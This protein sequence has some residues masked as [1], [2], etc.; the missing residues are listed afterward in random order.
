MRK[1][2]TANPSMDLLPP[3]PPP[4]TPQGPAATADD[5]VGTDTHRVLSRVASLVAPGGGG[6]KDGAR[7]RATKIARLGVELESSVAAAPEEDSPAVLIT[8]KVA[9][10]GR[11]KDARVLQIAA[12]VVGAADL[13]LA[14][15][16]VLTSFHTYVDPGDVEID[17]SA[18]EVHG[19]GRD[20]LDVFASLPL[21]Y[22]MS[23]FEDWLASVAVHAKAVGESRVMPGLV[24]ASQSVAYD[25]AMV[26]NEVALEE[27][28]K[29]F[30][31][32][33]QDV[34][35]VGV[36]DAPEL[37]RAAFDA[38]RVWGFTHTKGPP[39]N[40]SLKS[41]A[42]KFD[43]GVQVKPHDAVD[44]A[45]LLRGVLEAAA[46]ADG[47]RRQFQLRAQKVM[48]PLPLCK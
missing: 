15:A 31:Q 27:P 9:T 3:A 47:G 24:L 7:V 36:V 41:L 4:T 18:V 48:K 38:P 23:R 44:D 14:E 45:A 28:G 39:K 10:S 35:F 33:L 42:A 43:A 11:G 16:G 34:G 46:A 32:R 17:A 37:F 12:E 19:V 30:V 26:E 1:S 5:G 25:L 8:F 20:T 22:S 6:C 40:Y 21:E 2:S 29:S 13:G